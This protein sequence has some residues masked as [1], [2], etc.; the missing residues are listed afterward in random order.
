VPAPDRLERAFRSIGNQ[1]KTGDPSDPTYAYV[2]G[3]L[4]AIAFLPKLISLCGGDGQTDFSARDGLGAIARLL[5]ELHHGCQD[6][7]AHLDPGPPSSPSTAR[8][9]IPILGTWAGVPP[10]TL[11]DD[12]QT[13]DLV[14]KKLA[15]LA[16][17][18]VD[19]ALQPTTDGNV[20]PGVLTELGPLNRAYLDIYITTLIAHPPTTLN[21]AQQ[22]NSL[23]YRMKARPSD[24]KPLLESSDSLLHEV[25]RDLR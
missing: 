2:S 25:A 13:L 18:L 4:G 16:R 11:S 6:I 8:D 22:W 23:F 5:S 3:N 14:E 1:P 20:W 10:E 7:R 9:F 21:V 17:P 15:D 24:L 12:L 19:S